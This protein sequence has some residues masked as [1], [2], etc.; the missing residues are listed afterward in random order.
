[1][2]VRPLGEDTA[3]LTLPRELPLRVGDRAV[4][5]EPGGRRPS[6]GVTVLD[7]RPPRLTRLLGLPGVRCERPGEEGAVW[8]DALAAEGPLLLEFM[9]DGDTPP[10][11]AEFHGP[12]GARGPSLPHPAGGSPR[13]RIVASSPGRGR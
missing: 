12:E 11:W 6:C 10:D 2:T 9:V 4:L 5:R 3:R 7:V 1:M 13:R 8:D